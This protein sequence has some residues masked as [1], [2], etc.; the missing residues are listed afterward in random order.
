[1][2]AAN[3]L[4]DEDCMFVAT[5]EDETCP[6]PKPNVCI[7][8]AGPLVAAV[9]TASGREPLVVG[10]PNTAS[11][12]YICKRW[13]IDPSKTMMIGDRTNTDV[14]FGKDHG[15]RTMLVLSGCHQIDDIV[16]NQMDERDDMVPEYY[17]A[18][19]GSLLPPTG[20]VMQNQYADN[21]KQEFLRRRSIESN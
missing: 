5:N 11:F 16:Q 17:A 6:G 8:D 10:K 3:Y 20:Q 18:N 14:K 4:Q 2:K 12:N 15:L 19:L 7:P 9:K 1:M 21:R 13:Q